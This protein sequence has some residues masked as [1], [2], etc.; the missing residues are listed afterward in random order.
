LQRALTADLDG[1]DLV[2]FALWVRLLERQ[3]HVPTDGTPDRVFVTTA[4][5]GRWVAT[6]ARF[7]EGKV[8][9]DDLLA[10]ASTPI[11]RYEALFYAAM[12]RRVSGDT[13]GGDDLL[14]QVVAGTGL[15]LSEVALARD[16]LDPTRSQIGGP[17]PTDVSIP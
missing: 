1:D 15:D 11:Q 14:R 3:L 12:D 5:D 9:G 2:Y 7:G 16:M 13:K 4:D 8:K 17:L 6:L 10:R